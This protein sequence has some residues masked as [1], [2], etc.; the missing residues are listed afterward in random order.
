MS[1]LFYCSIVKIIFRK[2]VNCVKFSKSQSPLLLSAAAHAIM[3][4]DKYL[5]LYF[6]FERVFS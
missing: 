1:I 2:L 4:S 6:N 3:T 5:P